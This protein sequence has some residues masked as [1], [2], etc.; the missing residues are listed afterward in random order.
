M[1]HFVNHRPLNNQIPTRKRRK[2]KCPL[3]LIFFHGNHLLQGKVKIQ[4]DPIKSFK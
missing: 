4:F 1:K 3:P 2:F